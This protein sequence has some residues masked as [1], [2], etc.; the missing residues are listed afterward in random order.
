[1]AFGCYCTG[2]WARFEQ[3]NRVDKTILDAIT[4]DCSTF[5]GVNAQLKDL[6][7]AASFV[8]TIFNFIIQA[9]GQLLARFEGH[10]TG[11]GRCFL[12]GAAW[13][14]RHAWPRIRLHEMTAHGRTAH[15]CG[16]VREHRAPGSLA[17]W[18][19]L[20]CLHQTR[21]PLHPA[22]LVPSAVT[23]VMASQI[24]K[25]AILQWI[26]TGF[27]QLIASARFRAG[28]SVTRGRFGAGFYE[29]FTQAWYSDVGDQLLRTVLIAAFAPLAMRFLT[30]VLS[31]W[32]R[33]KAV[34][35]AII[36]ED[37]NKGIVGPPVRGQPGQP[38]GQHFPALP[39]TPPHRHP[40]A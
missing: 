35:K 5:A 8:T 2:L 39:H 14:G 33:K 27:I 23:N 13:Q 38:S 34:K 25:Q 3:T 7:T 17:C 29:D 20:A 21:P 26:N 6:A 4:T 31:K 32:S 30:F 11:E 28:S 19:P 10:H 1:M 12:R 9:I 22:P 24:V 40:L 37:L 18:H 15:D 36:Q 16:A